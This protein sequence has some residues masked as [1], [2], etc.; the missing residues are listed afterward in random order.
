[1]GGLL[2]EQS[3][4]LPLVNDQS[5]LPRAAV[6]AADADILLERGFVQLSG[7]KLQRPNRLLARLLS[8]LPNESSAMARLFG[9]TDAYETNMRGVLERR[10]AQLEGL[11]TRLS[12]YLARGLEDLPNHPTIFLTHVRGFRRPGLRTDLAGRDA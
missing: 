5:S 6:S 4:S 11:Y 2:L 10:I 3:R 8:E 9:S 1:V 7:N 12:T